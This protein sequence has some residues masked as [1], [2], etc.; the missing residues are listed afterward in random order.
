MA[1][2][3]SVRL[4]QSIEI[5][6]VSESFLY[7]TVES[8]RFQS[9]EDD[10]MRRDMRSHT[11]RVGT[12]LII[13]AIFVVA[14]PVH[15]R[16]AVTGRVLGKV[17]DEYDRG[18]GN[19][20]IQVFS[21]DGAYVK[22]ERTSSDGS[23]DVSLDVGK[24]YL[25]HFIGEGY[26]KVTRT[27]PYFGSLFGEEEKVNLGNITLFKA[28]RL[29]STVLSKVAGP[30]E[31]MTLSFMVSNIGED[32]EIVEFGVEKP[33]NWSTRIMDQT[34]EVSRI[35]L[36][37]GASMSLQLEAAIPLASTGINNLSITAVGKT[38]STLNYTVSVRASA[39]PL[40]SCQYPGKLA[41]PGEKVRFHVGLRNPFDVKLRFRVDVG[42][43]PEGWM[44]FVKSVA[45]E[46][47]RE[48]TL[49]GNDFADL[50]VEVQ[51]P[52]GEAEGDY[53]VLFEA[54]SSAASENLTL[55]VVVEKIAAALGV[56]L[57]A[58][59]PY[60]DAYAG[61]KARFR[62]RLAN[63]GGYDQLFD[64]DTEGLLQDLRAWFEGGDGQEIKKVYVEAGES[65]E[66]SLVVS[67]PRELIFGE[68][69]FAVSATSPSVTK[70]VSV[71]LNV[72]GV[73]DIRVMNQNFYVS[74]TVGGETDY[75]LR[76]MNTGTDVVTKLEA[77]TMGQVPSGFTVD[78][79]PAVISSLRPEDEG[80]F[81]ITVSSEPD[82]NAG[83][84]Y[85][86]MKVQSDQTEPSMFSLRIGVEPQMSWV[87]I[88][89]GLV[90]VAA[91]VLFFVYRKFGRR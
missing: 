15:V 84:Y 46:P 17:V 65:E 36:L 9:I 82:V 16:G 71:T 66:F 70:N 91:I 29:S 8:Y 78:V 34:G 79:E 67:V 89:G 72:L 33:E 59:L 18:M 49:E 52:R 11:A 6:R 85:V 26:V 90:L 13:F 14:S 69:D 32:Q 24:S 5:Y 31:K 88:G 38:S 50:T 42:S 47:V 55:L 44:A 41:A 30:G 23:F 86:E 74:L 73:H 43:V 28:L 10:G 35:W 22:S 48:V 37:S 87:Y 20:E 25:L 77:L 62:F 45:G 75:R 2:D 64:L 80:T 53:D 27:A 39:K 51:V 63:E 83:N 7:R 12:W 1:I 19:V 21:S 56:D 61:A 57:Q 60:L 68:L 3:R 58:M 76:V 81:T 40:V 54:S 4:F